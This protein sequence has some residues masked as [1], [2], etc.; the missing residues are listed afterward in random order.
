MQAGD[1]LDGANSASLRSP[2]YA[3]F[4]A[5]SWRKRGRESD[6]RDLSPDEPLCCFDCKPGLPMDVLRSLLRTLG[7]GIGIGK[8]EIFVGESPGRSRVLGIKLS[9]STRGAD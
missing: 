6:E 1:M 7:S 8:L 3:Q 5:A 9:R 2:I 4:D